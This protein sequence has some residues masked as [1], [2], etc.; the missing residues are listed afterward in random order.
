MIP[1]LKGPANSSQQ[2]SKGLNR[3]GFL[4]E[5]DIITLFCDE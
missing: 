5:H 1:N 3:K 2:S 4:N